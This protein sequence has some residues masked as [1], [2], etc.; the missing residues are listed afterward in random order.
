LKKRSFYYLIISLLFCCTELYAQQTKD[1]VVLE[2][3][4][5]IYGSRLDEFNA[6][7]K[8]FTT[9]SLTKDLYRHN[10]LTSLLEQNSDIYI[11]SYGLGSLST[12]SFR[13]AGAAQTSVLWNGFNLQSPMNGVLDLALVPVSLVDQVKLQFGGCGAMWGSGS[14]SGSI[15]LD[16]KPVY[17]KG[18]LLRYSGG[19]GSFHNISQSGTVSLSKRNYIISLKGFLNDAQNNFPYTNTVQ[20]GEPKARQTNAALRQYGY[21]L[22][23]YFK[24]S[25]R[26]QLNIRLWQQYSN[27]EI[28][29]TMLVAFSD[30]LQRDWFFRL[31]SELQHTRSGSTWNLRLAYFDENLLYREPAFKIDSYNHSVCQ[32]SEAET[33][34]RIIKYGILNL[35]I[36]NTYSTAKVDDYDGMPYQNRTALFTSIK[37]SGRNNK[38]KVNLGARKE[39]IT[40]SHYKRIYEVPLMPFAG[41][42]LWL[43]RKLLLKTSVSRNYR[44]PTFND[45][46]WTPGGNINLRPEQGWSEELGLNFIHKG[47]EC[48]GEDCDGKKSL[49][50]NLAISCTV[51]NR[52]IDNWIMWVPAG[53]YW[54]PEN[55]LKVWSRGLEN[56]VDIILNTGPLKIN[57]GARYDYVLSTN[58]KVPLGNESELHKQLIYVPL[59]KA[60]LKAGVTLKGY[61]LIYMHNYTGW[62]YT[63]ADNEAF[64]E[65]YWLG[66]LIFSKTYSI[67]NTSVNFLFKMNNI[68]N[69]K[70]QVI[71]YR[72]MPGQNFEIGISVQYNKK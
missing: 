24:I 70:Y 31:S 43:A 29:P 72:A 32:I 16:N 36:N 28:P 30:A 59:H 45:L 7:V 57:L 71:A 48:T 50:A 18:L 42:D 52:N 27:R 67:K 68:W 61:T 54:I 56:T 38:W 41:A 21:M 33:K 34:I 12:T 22:D 15:H 17:G 11:K 53:N 44:L 25:K 37:Y 66:N 19:Y 14:V 20:F 49:L 65:P 55:V 58:E 51:F 2:K 1:S 10:N 9:D 13:G 26:N 40:G 23:N 62:V 69:K 8:T 39:V 64:I 35:G 46:Y 4:V 47:K 3:V 6:G 5:V 60:G 63:Q